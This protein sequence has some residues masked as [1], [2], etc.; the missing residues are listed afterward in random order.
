MDISMILIDGY[1]MKITKIMKIITI[2]KIWYELF[3]NAKT[4]NNILF[5]LI[6]SF[7]HYI[8]DLNKTYD[9]LIMLA[10]YD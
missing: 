3:K 7:K 9:M 1:L 2:F 8:Y 4:N 5:L 10:Y 6:F